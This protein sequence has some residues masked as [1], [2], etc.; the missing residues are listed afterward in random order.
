MTTMPLDRAS[1]T[2]RPATTPRLSSTRRTTR[3]RLAG[4]AAALI[5]ALLAVATAIAASGTQGSLPLRIGLVLLVV[6]G[7]ANALQRITSV[8]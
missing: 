3:F 4:R 1:S 6:A 5:A 8:G 2:S 7:S